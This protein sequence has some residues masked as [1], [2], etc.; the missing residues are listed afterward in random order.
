MRMRS[1]WRRA[2]GRSRPGLTLVE[3]LV[4]IALLGVTG[5]LLMPRL[6]DRE[7]AV[8]AVE[9]DDGGYIGI[10]ALLSQYLTWDGYVRIHQP[11]PGAPAEAAGLQPG[12]VIA[13]VDGVDVQ[14]ENVDT[15]RH[16]I[17]DGPAGSPVQLTLRRGD[18]TLEV[19]IDR[20]RIYPPEPLTWTNGCPAAVTAQ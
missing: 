9:Q 11:F 18:E 12:D 20:A 5:A 2:A 16:R 14:N 6:V 8:A 10:G 17:M 15:V 19:T 1:S 7:P 13:Q 4:A 3:L